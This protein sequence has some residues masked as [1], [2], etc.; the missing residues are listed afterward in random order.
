MPK[1]L[2]L[3]YKKAQEAKSRRREMAAINANYRAARGQGLSAQEAYSTWVLGGPPKN[4][5]VKDGDTLATIA[6]Q[7][8]TTVPNI[9]DANPELKNIRPGLVMNLPNIQDIAASHNIGGLPSNA[10][11]GGTTTNPLGVNPRDQQ[12][13]AGTADYQAGMLAYSNA[14][15]QQSVRRGGENPSPFSSLGV[16]N[17]FAKYEYKPPRQGNQP[18]RPVGGPRPQEAQFAQ[19]PKALSG[20]PLNAQQPQQPQYPQYPKRKTTSAPRENMVTLL[21]SITSQTGPTGRIPTDFELKLLLEHGRI[22]PVQQQNTSMYYGGGSFSGRR[23]KKGGG[24]NGGGGN[25]Y[26]SDTEPKFS[27]SGGFRGLV[28]WRI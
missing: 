8:G 25:G 1:N 28:N 2:A 4:Y 19:Q 22:K 11:L 18:Y 9:L 7:T 27:S 5:T 17:P 13:I 3:A 6:G 12:S 15:S 10:A 24:G 21:D 20:A 26:Y 14:I 16:E 23:R